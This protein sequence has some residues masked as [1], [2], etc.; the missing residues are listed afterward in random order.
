M[1][2]VTDP[3]HDET[4]GYALSLKSDG[5][6]A[7]AVEGE[8]WDLVFIDRQ[9]MDGTDYR[10]M[11][12]TGGESE[13]IGPNVVSTMGQKIATSGEL[14]TQAW[15]D[16]V[17]RMYV[18]DL[19]IQLSRD[20]Y[21]TFRSKDG[22]LLAQTPSGMHA[23]SPH[24]DNLAFVGDTMSRGDG[25]ITVTSDEDSEKLYYLASGYFPIDRVNGYTLGDEDPFE[26]ELRSDIPLT[27]WRTFT[28]TE[29]SEFEGKD[30]RFAVT[31]GNEEDVYF[32][33]GENL[34]TLGSDLGKDGAIFTL[35]AGTYYLAFSPAVDSSGERVLTSDIVP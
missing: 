26:L 17:D 12:R 28:V 16:R 2:C 11:V 8:V 1:F 23:V 9:D 7:F 30:I 33:Y 34:N 14:L 19:V 25:A 13:T 4:A 10:F 31:P 5:S 32:V 15:Q 22:L 29:G 6:N 20:Q 18:A 21:V 3:Y 27:V 35:D 24:N